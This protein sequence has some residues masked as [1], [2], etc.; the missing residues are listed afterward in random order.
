MAL[1]LSTYHNKVDK[2]G[3]VSVPAHFR[4]ALSG[5]SFHGIVAYPSFVNPCVEAS[6]IDRIEQLSQS[7]DSLDPYSEER[8][9][10]ATSILGES[11]QLSFDGEGRIMLPEV[12]LENA[13]ISDKAV[14]VGKG[15]TFEIW[16][17]EQFKSYA[18][19]ARELA[20]SQREKLRLSAVQSQSNA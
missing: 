20:R 19:K 14:F 18:E 9:A 12:L 2:K 17:P 4:N 16:Q 10:F 7:I 3:R 6:G 13:G 15:A 11:V 8:D 1:F 5:Q